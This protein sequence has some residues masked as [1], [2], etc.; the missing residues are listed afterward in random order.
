MNNIELQAKLAETLGLVKDMHK[1][2]QALQNN[3]IEVESFIK[4]QGYDA[5]QLY[6]DA[7]NFENVNDIKRIC[8]EIDY[9]TLE[10]E[11]LMSR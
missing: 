9:Y 5:L 8:K 11:K 4:S 6:L 2:F 7:N 3:Y 10:F 1:D